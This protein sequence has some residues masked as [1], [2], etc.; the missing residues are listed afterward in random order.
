MVA[1]NL[2][3]VL[4]V[5]AGPTGLVLAI[6]LA[7]RGIPFRLID[8]RPE[9]ITWS[10]AIFIKSRTLEILAALGLRDRFYERGQIVRGVE[11]YANEARMASYRFGGLDTPFPHILSIPEGETIG[12]L[13]DELEKLGGTVE[14][15]VEFVALSQSAQHVRATLKCR[16]RGEFA[17]DAS[18]VVGTDGNHSAVRDAIADDFE[19]K[20]YPELWGVVDTG[21][22][23]WIHGRDTVCAQLVA[24]IAIPFPLGESLWRVYFCTDTP[25]SCVLSRVVERLRMVSPHVELHNPGEPQYFRSHSRLARR[26]RIGRVFL[27]GDAAHAS[28]PLEGHGMNLG[29]QDAYNLGWKLSSMVSDQA[30]ESLIESYEAERRQTDR[31][32]VQSG[33]EAYARM[34]PSG[35]AALQD[36]FAFLSTPDGQAFAALAESEIALGYES[37]PVVEEIGEKPSV[38]PRTTKVGYRVGDVDDL[39][40]TGRRCALHD[41]MNGTDPTVFVLLGATP[42]AETAEMLPD[43][44]AAVRDSASKLNLYL[45]VLSEAEPGNLCGQVVLDPK[46]RLHERLGA[47]RPR[48]CLVRPD[49]HL[50][51]SCAPPSVQSLKTYLGGIFLRA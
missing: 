3:L 11:A 7:H 50:G 9:P 38:S 34:M 20:D 51:F 47:D 29:I 31:A 1:D 4:I 30:T 28:N 15:G 6:E 43:L 37:S 23:N 39:I 36:L 2:K 21:L 14:R 26:F 16:Q 5:G 27:A 46:G 44:Q 35:A 32:I 10:Q 19:G 13:T 25:D 40:L 33:D 45:V 48:L 49:G 18:Y 22:R 8:L 17:V 12:I 24:P 41:L 42:T